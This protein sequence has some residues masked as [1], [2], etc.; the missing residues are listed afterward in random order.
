MK[1]VAP[2]SE[3]GASALLIAVSML[4][5]LGAAALAV[6]SSGFFN[7]ARGQ[8]RA[9]DLACLAGAP[10]LPTDAPTAVQKAAE[11]VRPNHPGLNALDLAS[12]IT[13]GNTTTFVSNDA[14]FAVEIETPVLYDGQLS[15]SVMRVSIL[16]AV[17]TNFGRVIGTEQVDVLQDAYCGAFTPFGGGIIPVGVGGGFGGGII[18]F[19]RSDCNDDVLTD[20]GSGVCNYLDIDRA[21]DL[22]GG[23]A[24]VLA[25]NFMLGADWPLGCNSAWTTPGPP[26]NCN[27][28]MDSDVR[29]TN[30]PTLQCNQVVSKSGTVASSVFDGFIGGK[31]TYLGRLAYYDASNDDPSN[32]HVKAQQAW[33]TWS[34]PNSPQRPIEWNSSTI[35]NLNS[36]YGC[37]PSFP[38]ASYFDAD[39]SGPFD[40]GGPQNCDPGEVDDQPDY[41]ADD[42]PMTPLEYITPPSFELN[43]FNC[44]DLRLVALPEGE[45]TEISGGNSNE[46]LFTIRGFTLG[47]IVDPI[48][49][50][51]DDVEDGGRHFDLSEIN[52]WESKFWRDAD[53]VGEV[54]DWG[55]LDHHSS[56]W[57]ALSV[58]KVTLHDS[59]GD[60]IPDP[61]VNGNCPLS[62]IPDALA[63]LVPVEI[64]LLPNP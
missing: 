49:D 62:P 41:D 24:D 37:T 45:W 42:E 50:R 10:H 19:N 20:S 60:G 22:G 61:T 26:D 34:T 16:Q 28:E 51:R 25:Y 33:S 15:S 21:D 30:D 39:Y 23:G 58:L 32:P 2:R 46:R 48:P 47:Y 4:F 35:D 36:I 54:S 9:A 14:S 55:S 11:F 12:G 59:D 56:S 43:A 40:P 27:I 5:L 44:H 1:A 57:P 53:G 18:K 52:D 31:G 7:Q 13:T 29:C 38:N 63:G 64:Q 17:D 3:T 6:D 8:Q